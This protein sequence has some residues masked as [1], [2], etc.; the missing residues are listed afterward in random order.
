M[1][2]AEWRTKSIPN[3]VFRTSYSELRTRS[4]WN[5]P[6]C[7]GGKI[8]LDFDGSLSL[9]YSTGDLPGVG[10]RLRV[11]PDH[12]VVE[13]MP[14]YAAEGQ[15]QH[16]YVNLTRAG[17]TTKEVQRKL[18][19]L[20]G[21]GRE[22]VGYAGLKDKQAR[23]TQTFSLDIGQRNAAQIDEIIGRIAAEL[24]VTVN[25]A[26]L[27]KNKLKPG[28]LLGNRFQIRVTDLTVDD[29]VA[30]QRVAAIVEALQR[31]GAVNFFGPQRFGIAGANVAKGR[32]ILLGGRGVQDRWLRRFLVSSYQSFLCNRYLAQRVEM[33]A[34]DYLLTGDVAKKYDT[35]G[36]FAVENVATEQ[37]RYA[38]HQISFTAPLYGPQMWAATDVAGELEIAILAEAEL[39]LAHFQRVKA[40]GSRR[41]GRLLVSDLQ[42][43]CADHQL[44]LDFSLPKGAFA[45][46]IV[47][48]FMKVDLADAPEFDGEESA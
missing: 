1:R 15:G 6:S 13:E 19:Q 31:R 32:E 17:L 29:H 24:P 44:T 7:F 35:G 34:F 10:G 22:A 28:H 4:L 39:T 8:M 48:E 27:H 26:R 25:W 2:N 16:L 3:S 37:E 41:L 43:V 23:T 36:M 38:A 21:S 18:E 40:E 46:T 9:P 42:F 12:F 47:R 14:L 33:G 30:Q 20:L 5:P 45:T 11:S